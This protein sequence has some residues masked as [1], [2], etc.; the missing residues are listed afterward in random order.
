[1]ISCKEAVAQLWEYVER[2]LPEQDVASIDEHLAVCRRCCGEAEFAGE[3]RTF[4]TVHSNRG[5]PS[6][7]HRRLDS[8]LG[9]LEPYS[10]A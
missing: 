1:M 7:V 6:D 2:D 4:M 5:L 9:A 3:L 10:E 8:F